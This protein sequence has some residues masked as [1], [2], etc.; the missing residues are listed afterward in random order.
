MLKTSRR[1]FGSWPRAAMAAA[2]LAACTGDSAKQ[3][4]DSRTSDTV[5]TGMSSNTTSWCA[6]LPRPANAALERV[7]VGSDWFAVYRVEPDVYA[8]VEPRQ[9]QEAIS[10][11][12]V[13]TSRALLFDAG[14]G[15]VPMRPVVERLTTLPVSVL[16]SHT[17]FDHVGANHEFTDI[18]AMDTP[19]TRTMERGRPHS[20]IADEV[21]P[22]SFCG[23][24]PSGVDTAAFVSRPFTV[25][26]RVA[27]GDTIDLGGRVLEI[28]GAPGH[29]PD[30]IALLDRARGLL[31]TGDSYYD[32]TIWL[33]S[34]GTDL[35]AYERSMTRLAALEPTLRRLLPAHNTA[36]AE[37][38]RLSAV[39]NAFGTART[40][41]GV[42]TAE[43]TNRV[44]V[45]VGD[46]TFMLAR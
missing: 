34:P 8:L 46:I 13:G 29:T 18:L 44:H 32:S 7:D 4:T 43:G 15:L 45:R 20:D 19:F 14:I 31:W 3:A 1:R 28:I 17:H 35:E 12:I 25:T 36:T 41:G 42:R 40:G 9:F 10:Y 11:L 16:N 22:D 5:S 23:V 27:D 33:F 30:A 2:V 6:S 24:P 37:P 39:V 21:A 26:R 38:S